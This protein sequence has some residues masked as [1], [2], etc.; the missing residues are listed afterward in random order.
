MLVKSLY[1]K[2]KEEERRRKKED[3]KSNFLGS[4]FHGSR[5]LKRYI[6]G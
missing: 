6:C 1:E 4:L 3:D 2:E 5:I